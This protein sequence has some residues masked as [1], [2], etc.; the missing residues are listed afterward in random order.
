[1]IAVDVDIRDVAASPMGFRRRASRNDDSS[2]LRATYTIQKSGDLWKLRR[3]HNPQKEPSAK[4]TAGC[5]CYVPLS[6]SSNSTNKR[7]SEPVQL[8]FIRRKQVERSPIWRDFFWPGSFPV[9]YV[10]FLKAIF[11]PS[12]PQL[13]VQFR[14]A[15]TITS[16]WYSL[17]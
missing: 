9:S 8:C 4:R 10:R 17:V 3:T 5:L 13:V 2:I 14:L 11:W 15:S 16:H 12:C 7:E 1:M 6:K